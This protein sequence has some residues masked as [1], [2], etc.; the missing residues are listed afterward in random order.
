MCSWSGLTLLLQTVLC[1]RG[2]E[3]AV[4]LPAE[5]ILQHCLN[6]N[7]FSSATSCDWASTRT[8][9]KEAVSLNTATKI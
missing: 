1:Q 9:L 3:S 7:Q 8:A 4:A 5:F 6:K 2:D